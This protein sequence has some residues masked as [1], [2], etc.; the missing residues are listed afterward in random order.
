MAEHKSSVSPLHCMSLAIQSSL[1]LPGD[2]FGSEVALEG[3]MGKV[4]PV[5]GRC[6]CPRIPAG[7]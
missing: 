2:V 1:G 3:D 4:L 7:S 6:T 5:T